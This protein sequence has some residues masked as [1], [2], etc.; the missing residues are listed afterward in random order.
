MSSGCSDALSLEDL[1]TAK[2]HQTFEAEVITGKAGGVPT[3]ADIDYAT[4]QV[5]GQAQKT[6]PAILRDAGFRPAAFT[7]TTGGTLNAGDSD[8]AVLWPISSGGDGQYYF[9]KG[10]LPK[11]I[12]ASSN[13]ASTGGISSSAWMPL[14]DITLRQDLI[15]SDVAKGDALL[16]VKQPFI[17]SLLRTQHAKNSEIVTT[18]DATVLAD[19]FTSG[20]RRVIGLGKAYTISTP[21]TIPA[22]CRLDAEPGFSLMGAEVT[23]NGAPMLRA[24]YSAT[25]PYSVGSIVVTSDGNEYVCISP[26]FGGNPAVTPT[27]WKAYVVKAALALEVPSVFATIN[28]AIT[29]IQGAAVTAPVTILCASH[30]SPSVVINHPNGDKITIDGGSRSTVINFTTNDGIAVDGP[31]KLNVK[32]ITLTGTNWTSHGVWT[33]AT[34]GIFAIAG[35]FVNCD[36]VFITKIYYGFQAARGGSIYAT[37]CEASEAGDGGFF[38]FNGGCIEAVNC[39]SHDIYDSGLVGQLGYGFVAEGGATMWL[40]TPVSYGCPAGIFCNIGSSIR[41]DSVNFYGNNNGVLI[42]AGSVV[43][44]FGGTVNSNIADNVYVNNG[45]YSAIN[46]THNTSQKGAGLHVTSGSVARSQGSSFNNNPQFGIVASLSSVVDASGS[47]ISTGNTS[48][49]YSPA[50]GVAGNNNSIIANS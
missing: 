48:G 8:M 1:K 38:A 31:F 14:G 22:T 21:L 41:A 34:T 13:P 29:F 28:D 37:N 12:P 42:K 36:N 35:A 25:V 2:K 6:L 5:T 26:S 39:S 47:T 45:R 30:T 4:N 46:A 43:E 44:V 10:A 40:R 16:A 33:K 50:F 9:W 27:K 19:V 11:V 20:A 24:A 18:D 17:N 23:N 3:G 15:S 32:N 7:F 49:A